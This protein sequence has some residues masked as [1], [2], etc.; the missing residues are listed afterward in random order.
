MPVPYAIAEHWCAPEMQSRRAVFEKL[1]IREWAFVRRT[2]ERYGV[3]AR[4]AEDVAQEAFAVALRRIED[5][6]AARSARPWLFV[7]AM[8]LATNYRNLARH[9][10]EALSFSPP[11]VPNREEADAES[12]LVAGEEQ[13]MAR[14]LIGR[15]SPKLREVLVQHDLEERPMATIAA[16]LG[17]PLKTAHARLRLAR[18][19]VLRR[20]RAVVA[21][22]LRIHAQR[23]LRKEE[24]LFLREIFALGYA[25]TP[26]SRPAATHL[27]SSCRSIEPNE[28]L[29]SEPHI[30]FLAG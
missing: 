23:P 3:P 14:E 11:D 30:F 5:H 22:S 18:E 21:S 4:D 28:E 1:Y 24:L 10:V 7:I 9:R 12:A 2:V 29:T 19:E 8:Q 20:G 25:P 27:S 15:L 26:T 17:I 6:D 16:E 13:A